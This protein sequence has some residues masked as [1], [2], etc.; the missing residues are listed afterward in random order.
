MGRI[1]S[2]F[3]CRHWLCLPHSTN[4]LPDR[5]ARL[6]LVLQSHRKTLSPDQRPPSGF[7]FPCLS[8]QTAVCFPPDKGLELPDLPGEPPRRSQQ[9]C[10]EGGGPP[11]GVSPTSSP[12]LLLALGSVEHGEVSFRL[13]PCLYPG[14]RA[15]GLHLLSSES[16]FALLASEDSLNVAPCRKPWGLRGV[17]R[18]V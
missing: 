15:A 1:F 10:R 16:R 13:Q 18:L 3:L 6:M 7:W 5:P 2:H 8:P 17:P 11:A 12:S 4:D 14:G 9:R